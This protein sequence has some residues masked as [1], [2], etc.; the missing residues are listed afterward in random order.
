MFEKLKKIPAPEE[1]LNALP[2]PDSLR[3][4][5]KERDREVADVISG[6]SGK[7]LL[8][9]GPCSA[10][11]E[12]PVLEYV[13]RLGELS[14]K[15]KDKLVLVPR[16]YSSKSRTRGVG[17]MGMISQPDINLPEDIEKGIYAVRSLNIKA[18]GESGLT[19]ADEMLYP[20][21]Y[22]YFADL[23]SYVAV[24]ARSCENQLHRLAASGLNVPVGFKNPTGGSFPVMLNSVF[25]A[26]AGHIFKLGEW[27]VKTEGNPLAHCVL[28][29]YSNGNNDYIPNYRLKDV[30]QVAEEYEKCG[31]S[32]PAVIIDANHSNSGKNFKK[33]IDICRET[34]ENR[35]KNSV[36][37]S[38]VKGLMVESFLEEGCQPENTVY[39]KSV[40][41]PC[42]GWEDTQNLIMEIA[43]KIR[44]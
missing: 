12:K 13:R 30:L 6:K 9:A 28:R 4:L 39:G 21:N 41:D 10:H 20:E 19:A 1:V 16:I 27:Q 23:F 36:F 2:M 14:L 8:I 25:A 35:E 26:R 33:Q 7:F 3:R 31:L 17:Y 43:E 38:I 32:N 29:G 22:P 5:K 15:V 18:M 37:K 34:L 24:G 11:E 44:L 42:L 40:T